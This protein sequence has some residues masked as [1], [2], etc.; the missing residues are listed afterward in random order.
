MYSK[1]LFVRHVD[2]V[3]VANATKEEK[4]ER[5]GCTLSFKQFVAS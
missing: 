4:I 1:K 5:N 2:R 3:G